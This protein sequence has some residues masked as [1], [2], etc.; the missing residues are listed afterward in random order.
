M[1]IEVPLRS[2]PCRGE[3]DILVLRIPAAKG[4]IQAAFTAI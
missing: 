2:E 1:Q 4:S 3:V